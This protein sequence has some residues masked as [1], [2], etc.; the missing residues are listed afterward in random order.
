MTYPV[1]DLHCDTA[2]R[3][4]WQTLPAALREQLGSDTYGPGDEA[5]PERIR[6]LAENRGHLSLRAIGDLSWAQCFACYIPDELTP[7]QARAFYRHVRAYL[8]G[9]LAR[10][11]GRA[12]EARRA[13]DIRPRL[14]P[15]CIVAVRTIENATLFAHDLS[16]IEELACS[17]VLMASLSW[18]APGPL[19]SGH[20]APERGLT[21]LG[22]AALAEMEREHMIVDV[23]HL[24]DRCFDE[25]A[26]LTERP[27]VASHSNSRAV[28]G[29]RRNLTDAQFGEIR[30]R[31]G[32]VGLNFADIFLGDRA[33]DIKP[34]FDDI[35][36]HID[37][38]LELGGEY[39]IALGSDFD[40]CDTPPVIE[41]AAQ[42]PAFQQRLEK[43]F[44]ESVT[45]RLCSENALAFF[46]RWGR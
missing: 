33:P 28:C 4:A 13:Q 37:H 18:N 30:D 29:H 10:N 21:P 26:A 22:R 6:E 32:L 34:T 20:D 43:R 35:S 3:L 24:N 15:R 25:V 39:V 14:A 8:D 11:D 46:E 1:F 40:G 42:M 44:G 31:G 17:G 19:A 27:F 38:W 2:D 16:L 7:E 12:T 23:S 5:E 41:T 36:R 9:E 45:A